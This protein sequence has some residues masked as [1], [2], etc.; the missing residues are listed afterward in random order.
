[1]IS[2]YIEESSSSHPTLTINH[3]NFKGFG[4]DGYQLKGII[5]VTYADSVIISDCSFKDAY[6]PYSPVDIV[7]SAK[8]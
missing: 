6:L 1:M 4:S 2:S 7:G 5:S 3:C 8:L